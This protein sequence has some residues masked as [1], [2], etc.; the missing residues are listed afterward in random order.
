MSN[1][2]AKKIESINDF[3]ENPVVVLF[4]HGTVVIPSSGD[5]KKPETCTQFCY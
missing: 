4:T 2:I 1:E 3:N 5:E